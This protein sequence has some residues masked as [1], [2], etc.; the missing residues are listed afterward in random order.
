VGLPDE[1]QLKILDEEGKQCPA[2]AEGLIYLHSPERFEYFGDREKTDRS[3]RGDYFTLGDIGYLDED[4]WLFLCDRSA[5][6]IISGGVN[7]YPAEV[8]GALLEHPAVRDAGTIG[9]ADEKWG[10]SVLSVVELQ[11]GFEPSHALEQELVDFCRD[12]LAHYKCPR[13]VVFSDDLPRYD[14]GKLY[15]R[16]LRERYRQQPPA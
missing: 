5:D 2:G 6:L 1:G 13:R 8:D 9:V 7:I 14:T 12:R 3:F 4:G 11:S 15:R 16:L 10:E